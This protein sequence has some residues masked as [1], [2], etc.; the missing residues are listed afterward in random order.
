MVLVD[1]TFP[2]NSHIPMEIGS[3][4]LIGGMGKVKAMAMGPH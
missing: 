3:K 1:E 4:G 2:T